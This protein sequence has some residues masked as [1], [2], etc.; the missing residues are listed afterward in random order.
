MEEKVFNLLNYL[1]QLKILKNKKAAFQKINVSNSNNN[2]KIILDEEDKKEIN[3]I[4]KAD[5]DLINKIKNLPKAQNG[6]QLPPI[7]VNDPKDP[8]LAMYTDSLNYYNRGEKDYQNYFVTIAVD[9][10]VPIL[11]KIGVV[12]DFVL[13]ID[14]KKRPYWE[15]DDLDE[16]TTFVVELSACPD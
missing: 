9:P 8:R 7:Y 3:Q 2:E 13:T 6:R 4:Y 10:A 14:P 12:P 16:K 15:Q 1:E 11:K 5:F